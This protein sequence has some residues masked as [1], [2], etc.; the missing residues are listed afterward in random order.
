M[1]HILYRAIIPGP[2]QDGTRLIILVHT[3]AVLRSASIDTL[4]PITIFLAG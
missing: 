4:Q 3:L 2:V 1:G